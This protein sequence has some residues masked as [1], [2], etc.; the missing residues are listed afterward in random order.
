MGNANTEK[1]RALEKAARLIQETIFKCDPKLKTSEFSIECNKTVSIDGVRHEID[2]LI[3]TLPG[4]SYES[5]SIFECKNWKEPVGKNEVILLGAKVKAISAN[6]GVLVAR[7]FTKDAR[8]Q[9]NSDTRLSLVE[10]TDDFVAPFRVEIFHVVHD[11]V[12]LIVSVKERGVPTTNNPA[13]L[14]WKE[15]PWRFNDNEVNALSFVDQRVREML[16]QYEADNRA[17]YQARAN[18]FG[19]ASVQLVF[20][21]GEL[22]IGALDVEYMVL[23]IKFFVNHRIQKLLSKFELKGQ[24]RAFSFEPVESGTPGLRWEINLVQRL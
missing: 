15:K 2:I 23:Q 11:P 18:H 22:T 1:G 19:E 5:T 14:E 16:S 7:R 20:R 4:S 3:K 6:R 10:C 8:A 9:A 17:M 21:P 24:G 12:Q 13:T